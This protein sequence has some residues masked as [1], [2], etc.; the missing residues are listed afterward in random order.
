[1]KPLPP[2]FLSWPPKPTAKPADP[3]TCPVCGGLTAANEMKAYGRCE[4]CHS[5]P[6]VGMPLT[7]KDLKAGEAYEDDSGDILFIPFDAIQSDDKDVRVPYWNGE[8]WM[9]FAGY[10]ASDDRHKFR[11]VKLVIT[12]QK[13]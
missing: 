1:M 5:E 8:K 12:I 4:S 11:P 6:R 3:K 2:R 7:W 9:I 13:S 10:N